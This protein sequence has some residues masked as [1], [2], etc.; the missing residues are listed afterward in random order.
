MD[1]SCDDIPASLLK[2]LLK[3]RQTGELCDVTLKSGDG[4]V[5]AH[6]C[7]LAS[8][9]PFFHKLFCGPFGDKPGTVVELPMDNVEI[10]LKVIEFLYTGKLKADLSDVEGILLLSDYLCIESL[11]VSSSEALG[12]N[13]AS[14][15]CL[16]M[17]LMAERYHLMEL[18]SLVI[19]YMAPKL[20][21]VAKND[22]FLDLAYMDLMCFLKEPAFEVMRESDKFDSVMSWLKHNPRERLTNF[23]ILS[24]FLH[25]RYLSV[26]YLQKLIQQEYI[27]LSSDQ[28]FL[29][30][31]E[32]TLERLLYR[33][34]ENYIICRTRV[35]SHGKSANLLACNIANADWMKVKTPFCNFADQVVAV[36]IHAGEFCCLLNKTE[37][38]Y[39]YMHP[40]IEQKELWILDLN[41][42]QWQQ[43]SSTR[44]LPG[45]TRMFS[46]KTGLYA[47]DQ[48]GAMALYLSE[49]N[50]WHMIG[51]QGFQAERNTWYTIPMPI[52]N[53]IYVLRAFSLG[54]SFMNGEM[55]FSLHV[56]D[57]FSHEWE[58]LS[59]IHGSEL[60]LNEKERIHGYI[61]QP[62][63]ILLRDSCG[64]LR[65]KF[66]LT[67]RTW[68][69]Y[70]QEDR[71]PSFVHDLWGTVG[72]LDTIYWIGRTQDNEAIFMLYDCSDNKVKI[73]C[74]P[75]FQLSGIASHVRIPD[76]VAQDILQPL[77]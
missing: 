19:R 14:S 31:C 62:G 63:Y 73:V 16:Q 33:G 44:G 75:E 23:E 39:G 45:M 34:S 46:H 68:S 3:Q 54:Y 61:I 41:S 21:T 69:S 71:I 76:D 20:S 70:N 42:G 24:Q 5:Q 7:V 11:R 50:T 47:L 66:D 37:D 65:A 60:N 28:S 12:K 74:Q 4:T 17:W 15:N 51:Q 2:G 55:G 13:L 49:T 30:M 57:T 36:G 25:P 56:F 32:A 8:G 29:Q 10:T 58:H 22:D 9:S 72:Y 26:K 64:M 53:Q 38:V 67:Q 27:I 59:D 43:K 40:M 1:V 48:H 52:D 6:G 35:T 77:L 18:K